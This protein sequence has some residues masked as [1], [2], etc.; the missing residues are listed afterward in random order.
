ME[1]KNLSPFVNQEKPLCEDSQ[2][3]YGI[4]MTSIPMNYFSIPHQTKL[5]MRNKCPKKYLRGTKEIKSFQN[6]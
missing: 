6:N 5:L 1:I 3:N 2:L 4:K